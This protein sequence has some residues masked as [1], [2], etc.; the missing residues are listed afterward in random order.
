M[1]NT[2][3][4]KRYA[5]AFFEYALKNDIVDRCRDDLKIVSDTLEENK[6]LRIILE[7]PFVSTD[8]KVEILTRI[9]KSYILEI[10]VQLLS[11][12]VRKGRASYIRYIF[13]EYETLYL[14]HKNISIVTITTAVELDDATKQRMVR[15]VEGKLKGTVEMKSRIDK[16]IIG[17]FI[18]EVDD[19][20]FDASVKNVIER[21][22]K[23]FNQN[24]FV[25]GY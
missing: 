1:R 18:V 23:N 20:R 24:V 4:V 6:E 19:Y 17:G 8:R 15:V 22:Y 14:K 3:L 7:K 5:K 10:G 13:E 11:M 25:K 16:S 12:M 9:F 21:L 2:L